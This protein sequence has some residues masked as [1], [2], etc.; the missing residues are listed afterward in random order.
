MTEKQNETW[1]TVDLMGHAQTAGRI[2]VENS[3]LRVDVPTT[4][5]NF[6]TEYYGMAAIYSVKIVSEEIARAY[7]HETLDRYVYDAPIV[8]RDEH[9]AAVNN[10]ERKNRALSY[11]I[12]EL[13]RRL[14]MINALPS[15]EDYDEDP[16]EDDYDPDDGEDGE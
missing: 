10:L 12:S 4:D 13:Q 11:Q 14:T 1:G 7:V 2:M 6:R 16:H 5:G 15:G 3:M 8:T 9:M